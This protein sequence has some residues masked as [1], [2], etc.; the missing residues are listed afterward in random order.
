MTA[1]P[2]GTNQ[3][4]TVALFGATGMVGQGVL[5]ECLL[6]PGVARVLAVGRTATG[7]QHPKLRELV[8]P[9]LGDLSTIETELAS[10]NACFFCVGVSSAGMSEERYAQVTYD[11]TVAAA[12]TLVRL[13]PAMTFVYVSG[14]G[15]D[16]SEHG[17]VMWARVKGRTENALLGMP[18]RAAYMFRPGVIIPGAGIRSRTT[19]YRLFYAIA[20]PLYPLL[21]RL[22]PSAVTTTEQMGRAMLAVARRGYPKRVL[23][24]KDINSI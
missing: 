6:D 16:S 9:S 18:F 17:R 22:S 21:R 3:T 15:T 14:T 12:R 4:L 5:R 13:N 8:V 1:S 7:Q 20:T 23:E 11:L 10:T 24:T 19:W 2:D